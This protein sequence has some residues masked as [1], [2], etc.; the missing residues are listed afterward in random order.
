MSIHQAHTKNEHMNHRNNL[1][2]NGHD[3]KKVESG[4]REE[5]QR[6]GTSENSDDT[7]LKPLDGGLWA[8]LCGEAHI[9]TTSHTIH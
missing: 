6:Q 5:T 1:W 4:L 3:S 7:S 9:T 8:W 2:L